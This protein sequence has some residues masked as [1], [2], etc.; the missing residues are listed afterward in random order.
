MCV[1]MHFDL[2]SVKKD[3]SWIWFPASFKCFSKEANLAKKTLIESALNDLFDVSKHFWQLSLFVTF[4]FAVVTLF[5]AKYSFNALHGGREYSP[6]HEAVINSIG[7]VFY[8]LPIVFAIITVF[9][10]VSTLKGYLQ[11]KYI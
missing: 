9:F 5:L 10:S 2:G 3:K 6:T 1:Y 11:S 8:L 7:W 4:M